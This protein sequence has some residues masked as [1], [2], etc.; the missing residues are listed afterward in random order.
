M[1]EQA[2]VVEENKR[3]KSN[4]IGVLVIVASIAIVAAIAI[5][6]FLQFGAK[7][8]QSEVKHNLGEAYVAQTAYFAEHGT[9]AS[10]DKCF[11]LMDWHPA[12]DNMYS[13]FCDT[14]AIMNTKGKRAPRPPVIPITK[15]YFVIIAVGDIDSDDESDYWT[16]GDANILSNSLFLPG[17]RRV[18][19]N[20]L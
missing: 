5:P 19:G 16:I 17:G 10:G 14:D 1:E 9:Y 12:P 11:E 3:R 2:Q 15:D 7:A 6:D 18:G 13:Y 8:K 20:D 4:T